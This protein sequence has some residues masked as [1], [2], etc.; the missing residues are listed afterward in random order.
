MTK[1]LL[2]A[3]EGFQIT[4]APCQQRR[5]GFSN[6]IGH[7]LKK[8]TQIFVVA[9]NAHGWNSCMSSFGLASSFPAFAALRR[10]CPARAR[11]PLPAL[12][13]L[14]R[15]LPFFFRS[16]GFSCSCVPPIPGGGR[17][18]PRPE[19]SSP[20]AKSGPAPPGPPPGLIPKTPP[21][22]PLP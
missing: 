4:E 5:L 22:T 13:V 7:L 2:V 14:P 18:G 12:T 3:N 15:F 19:A 6:G 10:S 1:I 11:P 16:S 20:A 9:P 17:G 21:L 8:Q